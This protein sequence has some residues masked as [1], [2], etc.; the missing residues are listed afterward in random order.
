MSSERINTVLTG[1]PALTSEV[2]ERIELAPV[3]QGMK[4][5]F[6]SYQ[7]EGDDPIS[8]MSGIAN[9]T[10]QDWVIFVTAKTFSVAER[11]KIAVINNFTGQHSE[12]YARFID[13]EHSYDTDLKTHQ[14]A[15]N[16]RVTY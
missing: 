9:I 6:V 1:L 2:G 10:R 15:L 13:S 3:D 8:D 16:Y 12:F 4:T 5:P 14:F 7:F 11:I